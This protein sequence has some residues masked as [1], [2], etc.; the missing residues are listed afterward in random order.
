VT[1]PDGGAA[2]SL[3]DAAGDARDE[4]LLVDYGKNLAEAVIEAL[5]DWVHRSV[6]SHLGPT[7]MAP[8][9]D[10]IDTAGA[11]AVADVG[12]RLADLLALDIDQQWTNPLSI[13]RAAAPYP[14]E[15]L[16][17]AGVPA[18]ERD[19]HARQFLPDDHYDLAPTSFAALGPRVHEL[20]IAWGAAKAHVHLRRRRAEGRR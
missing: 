17:Q 2:P 18:V 1:D 11:R 8:L 19:D 6:A 3:D 5:P 4:Q 15:I 10:A 20:G 9:Q 13:L 16:H 12:G 14:T 7:Q